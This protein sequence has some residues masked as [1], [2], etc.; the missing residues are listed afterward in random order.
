MLKA[1][2]MFG[3]A[4][5]KTYKMKTSEG[6]RATREF[7]KLILGSLEAGN[8]DMAFATLRGLYDA[9]A[10]GSKLH[11]EVIDNIERVNESLSL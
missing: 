7:A 5:S 2:K 6:M 8:T 11:Q 10:A 4:L 9:A 3:G 1:E